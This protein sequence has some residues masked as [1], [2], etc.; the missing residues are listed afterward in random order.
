MALVHLP[1]HFQ[2]FGGI[3]L[4]VAGGQVLSENQAPVAI[5]PGAVPAHPLYHCGGMA[6]KIWQLSVEGPQG[7]VMITRLLLGP[8]C[9]IRQLY[10]SVFMI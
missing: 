7:K 8:R 1:D 6:W 3:I 5:L 4:P 9:A 2:D 10:S